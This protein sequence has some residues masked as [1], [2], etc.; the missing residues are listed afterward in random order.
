[1]INALGRHRCLTLDD[2]EGYVAVLGDSIVAQTLQVR[3]CV[4]ACV[5]VIVGRA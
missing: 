4:R 1:M 2:G 5:C 3:V